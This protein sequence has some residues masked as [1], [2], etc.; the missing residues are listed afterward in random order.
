[1]KPTLIRPASLLALALPRLASAIALRAWLRDFRGEAGNPLAQRQ[2]GTRGPYG[3]DRILTIVEG[4][5]V[6]PESK[7]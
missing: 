4:K 2:E 3:V 6:Q 5:D 7:K 1:M